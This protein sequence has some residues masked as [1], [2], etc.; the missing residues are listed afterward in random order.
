MAIPSRVTAVLD[1]HA[2]VECFGVEREVSTALIAEPIA[3]G[4]YVLVRSGRY[5]VEIIDRDEAR[6]SLLLMEHLLLGSEG[7]EAGV[8]R[9][10]VVATREVS[11]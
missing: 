9:L 2:R 6:E 1:G 3:V 8:Q 4:D 5:L 7:G 10:G 11:S